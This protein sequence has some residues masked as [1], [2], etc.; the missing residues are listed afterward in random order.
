M[1]APEPINSVPIKP[2]NLGFRPGSIQLP[3]LIQVYLPDRTRNLNKQNVFFAVQ[4]DNFLGRPVVVKCQMRPEANPLGKY[5]KYIITCPNFAVVTNVNE[6]R[7]YCPF[8]CLLKAVN[9]NDKNNVHDFFSNENW[10]VL[11]NPAARHHAC[12]KEWAA[13]HVRAP[14]KPLNSLAIEKS[15]R[16]SL[17]SLEKQNFPFSSEYPEGSIF[18][19]KFVA[20]YDPVPSQLLNNQNFYVALETDNH[21]GHKVVKKCILRTLPGLTGRLEVPTAGLLQNPRLG[22]HKLIC[23]VTK[24]YCPFFSIIR[25]VITLNPKNKQYFSPE[26]WVVLENIG[27]RNHVCPD[28]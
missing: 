9:T 20:I 6:T 2:N 11:G 21:R 3:K 15:F 14:C 24:P 28:D 19:P 1:D 4:T 25:A 16:E 13:P 8:H 27:A 5:G 26:N 22:I 12:A 10:E 23:S 18:F 17:E 7:K